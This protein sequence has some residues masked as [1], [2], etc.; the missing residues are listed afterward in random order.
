MSTTQALF[1][2]KEINLV[3][4]VKL[5]LP[6]TKILCNSVILENEQDDGQAAQ[7]SLGYKRRP[8]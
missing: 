4:A 6:D 7:G 8:V 1:V 5:F 3:T 2:L